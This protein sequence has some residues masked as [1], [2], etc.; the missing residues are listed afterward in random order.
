MMSKVW[1]QR[2]GRGKA[3][4]KWVYWGSFLKELLKDWKGKLGGMLTAGIRK[5]EEPKVTT[6][7][8]LP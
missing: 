7:R 5:K 8:F 6:T 3:E 1:Q 2:M 4:E